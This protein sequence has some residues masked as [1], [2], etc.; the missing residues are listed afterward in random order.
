MKDLLEAANQHGFFLQ[1]Y[2]T[3]VLKSLGW[4]T[5]E[6][7][8]VAIGDAS[9]PEADLVEGRG[10]VSARLENKEKYLELVMHVQAKRRLTKS[11]FFLPDVSDRKQAT[12]VQ[13]TRYD[14]KPFAATYYGT[15]SLEKWRAPQPALCT[16]GREIEP[17]KEYPPKKAYGEDAGYNACKEVSVAI[18]GSIAEDK[19]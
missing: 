5:S 8:P 18:K 11:W 19:A 15:I 4:W 6:E 7:Y 1:R 17:E 3:N 10:D 2:C 9:R 16:I 14:T 12:F 13:Q